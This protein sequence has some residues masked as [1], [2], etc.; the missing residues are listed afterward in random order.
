MT[1][2]KTDRAIGVLQILDR[3]IRSVHPDQFFDSTGVTLFIQREL[4][5]CNTILG[6]PE[7]ERF[8]PIEYEP[9]VP[10]A[11]YYLDTGLLENL[12]VAVRKVDVI[13]AP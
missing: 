9:M 11:I 2:S 8:F 12:L 7:S 13:N 4:V 5:T 6:R 10:R 3:A 1:P